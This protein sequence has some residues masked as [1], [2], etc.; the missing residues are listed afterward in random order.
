MNRAQHEQLPPEVALPAI[1]GTE[2]AAQLTTMTFST[3]ALLKSLNV[4]LGDWQGPHAALSATRPL[5]R[6]LRV[7]CPSRVGGA[8]RGALC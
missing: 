6:I 7:M 3:L 5:A 1:G 4:Q 2:G 8:V